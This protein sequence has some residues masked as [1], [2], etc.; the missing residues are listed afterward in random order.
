MRLK[1]KAAIVTG[2]GSGIGR[3]T[4]ILFA[5]EGASVFLSDLSE[6]GG[7]ETVR[8]IT[9]AGGT[10]R[11]TQ[12]D[13]SREAECHRVVEKC[14]QA[15]GKV[16]VLVNNAAAFVLKS[17]LEATAEDWQKVME[18]NVFGYAYMTRLVAG[19]MKKQGGGTIVN[20][21]SIS[22]VVA[23]PGLA[24]YNAS[25]GAV[26]QLT[27]CAALDLAPDNIRVNCVCPGLIWTGQVEKMAAEAGITRAQGVEQWAQMQIMKRAGEPRE[28]A[29]AILFLA[30]EESSFCTG[31]ALFVDG[32]Y[33][34]Q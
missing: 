13:M 8:L 22:S 15:F 32:G 28:V 31:S 3:A 7:Q 20:L 23:Q 1:D 5:A 18:T 4:C 11:F 9:A 34:A 10:A 12:A 21:A 26:L 17:V 6:A 16:N 30:S 19:E 29:Q 14:V 27:R 24:T 33:T 25:K 2:G